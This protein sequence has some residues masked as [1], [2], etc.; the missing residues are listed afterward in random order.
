M[1]L[2]KNV[3]ICDLSSILSSGLLPLD[4]CGNNNWDD[5]RRATNDTSIV[6]LFSPTSELNTFPK[7]YGI[8]LLEV[9]CS[10]V[11]NAIADND[12]HRS[13]YI[14]YISAEVTPEQIRRVI[15]PAIFRD[16]VSLP[17]GV[18]VAWCDMYAEEYGDSDELHPISEDRLQAFA[19]TAGLDTVEY[20]YFRGVDENR[21]VMDLYNV[22][23]VF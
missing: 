20:G 8:A 7:S 6:Y 19:A 3:D 5:G 15:I 16:R 13:D 14:E 17:E 11:E 9:E 22:R 23:Y 21:Q 12:A 4:R 10:A 1:I 18:D 2:Y